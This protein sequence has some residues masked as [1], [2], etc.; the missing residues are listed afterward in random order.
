MRAPTYAR[1]DTNEAANI[2]LIHM[3][4]IIDRRSELL[5]N[6]VSSN[7]FAVYSWRLNDEDGH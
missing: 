2:W 3:H 7:L 5:R 1:T 4:I 6:D